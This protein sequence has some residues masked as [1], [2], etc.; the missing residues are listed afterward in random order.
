[1]HLNGFKGE[2]TDWIYWFKGEFTV[3]KDKQIELKQLDLWSSTSKK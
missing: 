3:W 2:F 1:M